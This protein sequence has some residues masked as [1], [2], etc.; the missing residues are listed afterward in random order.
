M[1]PR[2][3]N[4]NAREIGPS[5]NAPARLPP[6]SGQPDPAPAAQRDVPEPLRDLP[7]EDVGR[8]RDV[9]ANPTKKKSPVGQEKPGLARAQV[10]GERSNRRKGKIT[11]QSAPED[12]HANLLAKVETRSS[13]ANRR[14]V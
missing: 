2:R 5:R 10:F 7:A 9:D 6:A 4:D 14:K 3:T 1:V 11:R 13:R 8:S 12:R